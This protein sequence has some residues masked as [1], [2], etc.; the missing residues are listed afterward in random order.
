MGKIYGSCGHEV[1]W[2][3]PSIRWH[4]YGQYGEEYSY[5]VLCA[6]CRLLYDV[7][8]PPSGLTYT[9]PFEHEEWATDSTPDDF[10]QRVEAYYAE[11]AELQARK[12]NDYT[13]G[14]S[15]YYNYEKTAEVMG[16]STGLAM[17]G[18]LNEKVVRLALALKGNE[19]QV[20]ESMVDSC[21]DITILAGL[22]A[23]WLE[24]TTVGEA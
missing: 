6:R 13:A 19:L 23:L 21:R 24:D 15:P 10:P 16:C 4:G 5:G 14:M 20:N 17:L 2:D 18:R 12:R 22:I 8:E 11:C 1:E 9:V 3:A 7:L